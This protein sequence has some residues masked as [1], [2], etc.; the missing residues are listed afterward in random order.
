MAGANAL[1][2][3]TGTAYINLTIYGD[4]PTST[5]VDEGINAGEDFVLRLW[6]SSEDM[7]YEYGASF[8]CWFNNNGA[9]MPGCGSFTTV[10]DFDRSTIR[11]IK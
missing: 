11:S 1:I 7:I 6:D 2:L 10:Y 5:D 8:D 4:D 3:D 9:P